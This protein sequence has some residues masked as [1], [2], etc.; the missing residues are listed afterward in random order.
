MACHRKMVP[1]R[2]DPKRPRDVSKM[3]RVSRSVSS[4][5]REFLRPEVA[6]WFATSG[7]AIAA[8]VATALLLVGCASNGIE[9]HASPLAI[10]QLASDKTLSAVSDRGAWPADGWWKSYNDVQLNALMDEAVQGSPTLRLAEARLA[11]AEALARVA[12]SSNS[13]TLSLDASSQRGRFS[14]NY[15]YPPPLGGQTYTTNQIGLNFNWDLDFWGKN[16]AAIDAA[17]A[18]ATASAADAAAARL[19]LT[20]SV[21]RAW[22]QLQRLYALRDVTQASIVQ[23]SDILD[24]TRQRVSAGLDTNVELR[25]AESELPQA[26]VDLA[27]LDE[28][29]DLTRNQLAALVGRG[30]DRGRDFVRPS[31]TVGNDIALPPALPL[32]L[33]GRRP[34]LTA[35]RWRVESSQGTI[36][37]AKA[38]FYPNIDLV[39]A[40]GLLALGNFRL[41]SEASETTLLGPAV[42][43]PIYKKSLEGNLRVADADYD[44][45]V[46]QYNQT[47]IEALQDVADQ[48]TSLQSLQLQQSEEQ[49]ALTTIE[50]A[51]SLSVQRYKAG[52][53]NYLT[54][55]TAETAVLQQRRVATDLKART[56]EL[57]V[58]LIRA[59]GGGY[60]GTLPPL[61][62]R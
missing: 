37:N 61:A 16:R 12:E 55:L 11:R 39:A 49:R 47:L 34:D 31:S 17:R 1:P 45:A 60:S 6:A 50:E 52:L 24:L 29:I 13:P 15:I 14:G 59:L 4:S 7:A 2:S 43:L 44:A 27:Q 33:I 26:R 20:T 46:E 5:A 23:R 57:N 32:A 30:P 25:Q 10:E 3:Q 48:I 38:Q 58:N 51:Y 56:L 35:A 9:P 40:A 41:L 42:S 21:A 28:R 8:A 62:Q 54:V 36:A 18:S 22:F 53:G 19:A